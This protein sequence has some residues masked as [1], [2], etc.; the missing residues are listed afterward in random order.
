MRKVPPPQSQRL[1]RAEDR[2]TD[3]VN[4]MAP[5]K[6]QTL[7]L[8]T[9]LDFL[10]FLDLISFARDPWTRTG[11][12]ARPEPTSVWKEM[13]YHEG[14]FQRRETQIGPISEAGVQCLAVMRYDV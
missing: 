9:D 7:T 2:V 1:K 3:G 14:I 6:P 13:S 5:A 10:W 12:L 11:L 4:G 8:S